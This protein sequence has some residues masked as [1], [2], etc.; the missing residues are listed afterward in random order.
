MTDKT[1]NMNYDYQRLE[2]LGDAVL[3]MVVIA[4]LCVIDRFTAEELSLMKEMMV[5]NNVLSKI[6]LLLGLNQHFKCS[7]H[8]QRSIT[9]YEQTAN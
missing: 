3:D 5:N 9:K 1:A 2:F 7:E 4:N 8:I 6:S